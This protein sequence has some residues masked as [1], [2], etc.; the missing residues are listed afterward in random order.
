MSTDLFGQPHPE[1]PPTPNGV[2]DRVTNDIEDVVTVLRLAQNEEYVALGAREY[3]W[4]CLT[5]WEIEPVAHHQADIVRQLLDA[6]WLTMGRA[7]HT[8]KH[9][10]VEVTGRVVLVL[11]CAQ[12]WLS[13]WD[14]HKPLGRPGGTR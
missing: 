10:G 8:Y 9:Q 1:P 4:R 12:R 7:T 5:G 13:R 6:G 2:P 14:S 11:T 3:L